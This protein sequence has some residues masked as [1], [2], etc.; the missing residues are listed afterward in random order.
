MSVF[1][2]MDILGYSDLIQ[3]ATKLETQEQTLR[4]LYSALS[5]CRRELEGDELGNTFRN[6]T[7]KDDFAIKTFTDN[8]VIG[9]P[10]RDNAESEFGTAFWKL[11]NFQFNM[12]IRGYF[13]RG[14][15]SVAPVY[16]DEIAVFGDA[17][18]E[19]YNGES[20]LARDPRI[21]LT[22]SAVAAAKEHLK[23]YYPQQSRAPHVR[24]ILKDADGQW[25]IN[26]LESVL[27]ADEEHGP[28][29]TEFLQHK[30]AVE[31]KLTMHKNNPPIWA[32]YTWI[33]SYHNYFCDL[34]PQLFES[35]HRIDVELFKATPSLIVT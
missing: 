24:D 22:T 10:I 27:I 13:I 1:V 15:I 4:D 23:Y 17:L 28:F 16:V 31:N 7:K 20:K 3:Q 25:F 32:K 34:H 18:G 29:Y 14:A 26:Y 5:I 30:S 9:W 12:A 33:A 19:A 2:F 11:A 21:I 35:E 8:I 6:L